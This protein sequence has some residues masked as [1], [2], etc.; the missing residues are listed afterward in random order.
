MSFQDEMRQIQ[1]ERENA[2][3]AESEYLFQSEITSCAQEICEC[4][5]EQLK[6]Q[7]ANGN[8]QYDILHETLFR[9]GRREH[10]RYQVSWSA[11]VRLERTHQSFDYAVLPYHESVESRFHLNSMKTF[12]AVLD[13]VEEGLREN[14]I[15]PVEEKLVEKDCIALKTHLRDANYRRS[16]EIV[17]D[18]ANAE[19]RYRVDLA[20]F[21]NKI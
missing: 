7:V 1:R 11:G 15:Y 16:A 4:I 10:P 20:C 2:L 14:G 6:T 18:K 9:R 3:P 13:A 19:I 21:I 17:Q 12:S 8:F 5:R